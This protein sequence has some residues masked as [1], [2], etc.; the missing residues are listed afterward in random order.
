[1]EVS[2]KYPG[3]FGE[4]IQGNINDI[5]LLMSFPINLYTFARVYETNN[6][7]KNSENYKCQ[8]FMKNILKQ[9]GYEKEYNHLGI[10]IISDISRG[11]GLA[12]STA[13]LCGLYKCLIKMFNKP[14]NVIELQENCITIEP[15]DSIIFP[16]ATLFDYKKGS[17][18]ET[19]GEYYKFYILGFIGQNTI[20]TIA[21]NKYSLPKLSKEDDLKETLI[22]AIREKNLKSLG[23][24]ST[25]S[26]KRNINRLDYKYFQH[27]EEIQKSTGGVGIIGAHSGDALGIIYENRIEM[28][29]AFYKI[30]NKE[31]YLNIM[32]FETLD[33]I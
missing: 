27:V 17:Y 10:S 26:I 13:D 1:M 28:D 31:K 14:Y 30:Y 21:F 3:S 22:K 16:K 23:M 5:D 8:C 20:D 19:I 12:S 11:K 9:W 2:A 29:S 6:I 33:K 24:V 4:I 7:V 15:T 32:P 25:E 18:M